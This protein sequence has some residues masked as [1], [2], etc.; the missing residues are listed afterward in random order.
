[1]VQV[2]IPLSL[3]WPTRFSLKFYPTVSDSVK[4]LMLEVLREDLQQIDTVH[5]ANGRDCHF[6]FISRV[7]EQRKVSNTLKEQ[8]L[9]QRVSKRRK[10]EVKQA[11][12]YMWEL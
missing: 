3:I 12:L 5:Q 10:G 9:Q 8:Q 1:M 2:K 6:R 4:L 7:C 11:R